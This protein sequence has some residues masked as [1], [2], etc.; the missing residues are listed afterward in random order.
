[1]IPRLL[2][3]RGFLSYNQPAEIDFSQIR[4][5][6]ISGENGA[7]KSSLLDA[8]TWAL[9]GKARG[10]GETLINTI[11][12][13]KLAEV[14]FEFEYESALYRVI[15]TLERGKTG[16]VEFLIRDSERDAWRT[17]TENTLSNTN[18]LIIRTLHLDYDTFVN[19][20]FFLQGKA[21]LFTSQTP[22]NRKQ[23]LGNILELDIWDRYKELA[24]ER[25]KYLA[26]SNQFHENRLSEIDQELAE[27]EQRRLQLESASGKLTVAEQAYQT[28]SAQMNEAKILAERLNGLRSE[29]NLLTGN[30]NRLQTSVQ[31]DQARL[32]QQ[33]K[34][35]EAQ[36]AILATEADVM[37]R[38][39]VYE[40]VKKNNEEMASKAIAYTRVTQ[41]KDQFVNRLQHLRSRLD[42]EQESLNRDLKE[43]QA[44]SQNYDQR[45]QDLAELSKKQLTLE[46]SIAQ[47]DTVALRLNEAYRAG[48]RLSEDRSAG[49]SRLDDI[50]RRMDNLTAAGYGSPCPFCGRELD[51]AHSEKYLAQLKTEAEE[52][53]LA[54][55]RLNADLEQ[56]HADQAA[57]RQKQ[58]MISAQ[59][60]ENLRLV[61]QIEQ[62]KAYIT[63]VESKRA[64]ETAAK[65]RLAEIQGIIQ[66]HSFGSDERQ[67]IA[68]LD[69]SLRQ[70]DY[71]LSAHLK[72]QQKEKELSDVVA[73]R[74]QIVLAKSRLSQLE[75]NKAALETSVAENNVELQKQQEGIRIAEETFQSVS[76]GLPD[77]DQLQADLQEST[78]VLNAARLEF[79]TA[80]QRFSVLDSL[81]AEKK[82]LQAKIDSA[83]LMIRRLKTLE[84]AFSKNGIPALLIE[85]ALPE[86]EEQTN[87]MLGRLTDGRMSVNI[88]TQTGLK[89]RDELKETLEIF[90]NDENGTRP[91]E[92]F[93]GGEMF[94]VNF[95][96]RLAL[97]NLL[98]KRAG[99][100][101][102]MLV[103]DEGFG[104]QDAEGRQRLIE[105]ITAIQEDYESILVIT[106]LE[107]LKDAFPQ[108]IEVA[109]GDNGSTVT[110]FA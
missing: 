6:C 29:L 13:N 66:N 24:N 78:K 10:S 42:A 92:M 40:T 9:F 7:G 83:K 22:K 45:V 8:V 77:M 19:V 99:A 32:E 20:S 33:E 43:L 98:A 41:E 23:I 15:R 110:V 38:F 90:I 55:N 16:R 37:S 84:Q 96:I 94:R 59:E 72:N 49:K 107:E 108:R 73:Q 71:D 48:V 2:Q 70:I 95:S 91:Y 86:I 105:A 60:A 76:Q 14:A 101:M 106:H 61:R 74:N 46:S 34:E 56:N 18:K 27:E 53:S 39:S 80:K 25:W 57:L 44:A 69:A 1:M 109:K 93:S 81:K 79:N 50:R 52:I 54:L 85:E 62:L 51:E 35:I 21:D 67:K 12:G 31:N 3:I 104:S 63:Q 97:A 103:I 82:E 100:R 28:Q 89:T 75:E 4:V 5:A 87:Q 88:R 58:E 68:E 47:K 36:R 11:G 30:F 64:N 102:Q 65:S 26:Q 17:L